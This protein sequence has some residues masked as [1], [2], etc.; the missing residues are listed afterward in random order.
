MA[1]RTVPNTDFD[2]GAQFQAKGQAEFKAEDKAIVT[3]REGVDYYSNSGI[4]MP[5]GAYSQQELDAQFKAKYDSSLAA[6]RAS[7][8]QAKI[9]H[10]IKVMEALPDRPQP[11]ADVNEALEELG[12]DVGGPADVARGFLGAAIDQ[13]TSQELLP[14]MIQ[15]IENV[16]GTLLPPI[17][18]TP[19]VS[20]GLA[21]K[22]KAGTWE[23]V[24]YADDLIKHQPKF[25]FLFKVKFLNF[26][27]SD[28][29]FEFYVHRC[30]KPK[31]QLVHQEVNYYNF[32]TKVLTNTVFSPIS[33][34]FLDESGD[35]VNGFFKEYLKTVSQQASG[36]VGINTGHTKSSS[37]L[38]YKNGSSAGAEIVI[39]QIF[40]NGLADNKFIFKNP[41]IESFDFDD[42]SMEDTNGSLMT[43]LFHYDALV[44]ETGEGAKGKNLVNNWETRDLGTNTP[45]AGVPGPLAGA[46]GLT[47][48]VA[49]LM[50]DA[51]GGA[52][53]GAIPSALKDMLGDTS[54][55]V[56]SVKDVVGSGMSMLDRGVGDSLKA[57]TSGDN[58]KFNNYAGPNPGETESTMMVGGKAITVYSTSYSQSYGKSE[59]IA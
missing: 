13:Y 29:K 9:D 17:F 53:S 10:A 49:G 41:R 22:P 32:R 20:Q 57:I 54:N 40:S 19:P 46:A 24:H 15:Q 25:K 1:I 3:A 12:V 34:T 52:V 59:R 33:M 7:L 45:V 14:S 28:K 44:C 2:G 43:I 6:S 5:G 42:L 30:D 38:P 55:L 16:A 4:K 36:G 31:V 8:E 27:G 58:L 48:G 56:A 39:Q 50:T 35:S 23:S 21:I 26:P 37:S 51:I 11:P 18:R 47:K